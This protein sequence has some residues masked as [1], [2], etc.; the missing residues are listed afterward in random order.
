MKRQILAFF[1]AL[2]LA[3]SGL[4]AVAG[5]AQ[6][7]TSRNGV[8]ESGELCMWQNNDLRGGRYDTAATTADFRQW[9][10][11]AACTSDCSLQDNVSSLRNYDPVNP[12]RLFEHENFR[13]LYFWRQKANSGQ[14]DEALNLTLDRD[15]NGNNWNDRF[16]S[17]CFVWAGQPQTRCRP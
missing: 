4:L 13:G 14:S 15:Q 12:V 5:P 9:T 6:A 2:A 10:F 11:V 7:S 16:S 8:C 17:F 1:G 3:A